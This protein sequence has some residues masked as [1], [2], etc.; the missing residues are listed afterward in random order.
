MGEVFVLLTY[1]TSTDIFGDPGLHSLPSEVVLGL[2]EG[3][4][5]SW[6]TCHGVVVN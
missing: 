3:F 1:C 4:I 6:V 5:S 2:L